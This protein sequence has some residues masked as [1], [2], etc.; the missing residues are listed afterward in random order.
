MSFALDQGLVL[1]LSRAGLVIHVC[2]GLGLEDTFLTDMVLVASLAIV[3]IHSILHNVTILEG[4]GGAGRFVLAGAGLGGGIEVMVL[5]AC[6]VQGRVL[7]LA[8]IVSVAGLGIGQE[9]G[10]RI[11]ARNGATGL[12]RQALHTRSS[13][14]IEERSVTGA[15]AIMTHEIN[16]GYGLATRLRIPDDSIV[17]K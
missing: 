10:D 1:A 5:R 8:V 6:A 15:G 14:L 11:G 2:A 12:I 9:L 17:G 4:A 7:V 16:A 3:E 13:I